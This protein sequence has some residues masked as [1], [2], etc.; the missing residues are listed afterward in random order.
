MRRK[1]VL[2]ILVFS[3][4]PVS[5]SGQLKGLD[6]AKLTLDE[7]SYISFGDKQ[8]YP[9]PAGSSIRFQ[10]GVQDVKGSV[11]FTISPDG[12]NIGAVRMKD[13]GEALLFGL[14]RPAAGTMNVGAD[15][16]ATMSFD[17]QL[18]VALRGPSGEGMREVA[19][20]FTTEA[21]EARSLDG[22]TRLNV[23]GMRLNRAA[24][25]V[26]FVGTSA[27]PASDYPAPGEAV[28]AV[29]SG[30]FDALPSAKPESSK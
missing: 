15:G 27:V 18:R 11:S 3:I 21:A 6:G 4:A 13:G 29:L 5:A 24:R 14:A 16:A 17:A 22:A 9:I 28:Y 25:A 23:A 2:L 20:H 10:F 12:V 19:I 8:I 7:L 30:V 26:Q 1:I